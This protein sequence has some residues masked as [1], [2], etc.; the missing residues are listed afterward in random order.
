MSDKWDQR[1]LDMAA[2]VASWSKDPS[3][4][5]GAVIMR[6]DKTIASVGYNGL[7]QGVADDGRLEDKTW[8][9][10]VVRHA[11]ENALA[12]AREPLQG[13][14][15][16]VTPLHPCSRCAGAIIQAGISRVVYTMPVER[17]PWS[18]NS[19]IAVD[20]LREAGVEVSGVVR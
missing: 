1:A 2:L 6:P 16:A 3:T 10:A 11:E 18:L 8:K 5:V 17:E 20:I 9:H 13:Y 4:K 14:M 19:I 7:P 12:F 15:L